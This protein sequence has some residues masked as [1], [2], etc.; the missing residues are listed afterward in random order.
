M[1][2]LEKTP[3]P[4]YSLQDLATHEDVP[5]MRRLRRFLPDIA[6]IALLFALPLI[7]FYQQTLG[8]R[9][10]LPTENLY[11][12][13]P[14]ATYSEVVKAPPPHNGLLDDLVLENMQ[15]KQFIA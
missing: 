7:M 10:L 2:Y 6:I 15:W 12:Y 4:V 8:G 9:T 3:L 5:F 11:K 1:L 13:E 14:F